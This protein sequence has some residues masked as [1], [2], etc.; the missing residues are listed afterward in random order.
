MLI[1][2]SWEGADVP[3]ELDE[4][5]VTLA[6]LKNLLQAALPGMDVEKV[7]LKVGGRVMDTDDHVIAL[8]AGSVVAMSPTLAAHAVATLREEG[9]AL[10]GKGF[11]KAVRVGDARLSKLYL[12]AGVPWSNMNRMTALHV[13]STYNY[14][15]VC[16]VLVESGS[17]VDAKSK[18]GT[19]PFQAGVM[20]NSFDACKY[21]I[22]C[23]CDIH[24]KGGLGFTPLEASEGHPA[25]H[26]LLLDSGARV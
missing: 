23:G 17:E 10:S 22:D 21:L 14:V 1:T 9:C 15:D 6:A 4:T 12:D 13:A 3:V 2:A 7:C 16:K 18:E 25:L 8:V 20:N 11:F 26:K 5:C 19:T 24:S